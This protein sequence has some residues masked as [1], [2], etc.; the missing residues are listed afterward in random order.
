MPQP[1]FFSRVFAAVAV[2]A[3]ANGCG[4]EREAPATAAAAVEIH[5]PA[6]DLAREA[7]G[8]SHLPRPQSLEALNRSLAKHYPA[9]LIGGRPRTS[10]LVDVTL[11]ENGVVK[12]VAVV[13]RPAVT[14]SRVVL[15]DDA[16]G[17]KGDV[18][19]EHA[20]IY[21]ASF[22]PAAVAAL[23]EVRFHPARREGRPVPFTLRMSVEFTSPTS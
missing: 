11:D 14:T 21:D 18:L 23:N 8:L 20:T 19:R 16:P 4:S 15:L 12:R 10:V 7:S 9:T 1:T 22:G 17:G 6:S 13:D 2:V 5:Q 3:A